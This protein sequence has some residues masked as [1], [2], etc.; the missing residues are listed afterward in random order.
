MPVIEQG[1]IAKAAIDGVN[2]TIN[3][4]TRKPLYNKNYRGVGRE[5]AIE[6]RYIN[7]IFICLRE[8]DF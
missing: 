8:R 4:M 3:S 5:M 7:Y 1:A 6:Q 2:K